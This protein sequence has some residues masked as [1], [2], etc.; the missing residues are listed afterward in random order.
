MLTV[1]AARLAGLASGGTLCL[2]AT[3]HILACIAILASIVGHFYTHSR[4][5]LPHHRLSNP[6]M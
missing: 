3:L 1:L 4:D 5:F 6:I 2:L